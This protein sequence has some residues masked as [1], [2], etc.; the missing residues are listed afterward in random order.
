V[1]RFCVAAGI[2][3]A[4]IADPVV[5]FAS[6]AG[7]FGHQLFT[8]RSNADVFPALAAAGVLLALF[9]LRKARAVLDGSAL[10][11]RWWTLLPAIFAVQ[12]VALY[13]METTEQLVV[14]GG[15]LGPTI[16]LGGPIAVSLAIHAAFCVAFAWLL[17]RCARSIAKTTLHVLRMIRAIATFGVAPDLVVR[18]RAGDVARCKDVPLLC[19]IGE[20]APPS[21]LAHNS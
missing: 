6:N 13:A 16:W 9:M 17:V 20:R 2:V 10:P 19:Q 7:W 11:R 18:L 3:A 12:L 8:D 1:L 5:E 21:M 15:I 14:R 4:A